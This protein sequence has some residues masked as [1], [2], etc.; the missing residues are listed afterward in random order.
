MKQCLQGNFFVKISVFIQNL[1][2]WFYG[3]A[4]AGIKSDC[5]LH[6]DNLL[7]EVSLS[8]TTSAKT[9]NFDQ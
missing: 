6:T 7:F 5:I 2:L 8:S 3:T 9:R 4:R 1:W